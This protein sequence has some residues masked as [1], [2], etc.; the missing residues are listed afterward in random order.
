MAE[1]AATSHC[2]SARVFCHS[3]GTSVEIRDEKIVRMRS[4][5]SGPAFS[6]LCSYSLVFVIVFCTQ[7]SSRL[8]M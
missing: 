6:V 2:D 8:Y 3:V 7:I 1:I 4:I 5:K